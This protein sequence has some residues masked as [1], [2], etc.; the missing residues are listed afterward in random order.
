MANISVKRRKEF[1]AADSEENDTDT[2]YRS[3]KETANRWSGKA[4][5]PK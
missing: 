4:P 2:L 1:D 3:D 5:S